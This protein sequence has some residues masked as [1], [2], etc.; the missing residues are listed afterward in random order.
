MRLTITLCALLP[1][2][3]VSAA[4][5]RRAPSPPV[6]LIQSQMTKA[7]FDAAG[8]SKLSAGELLALNQWLNAFAIA[9][10]SPQGPS[11]GESVIE[12][13]IEGDFE[14]WS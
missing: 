9:L 1:A 8:L 5:K 13:E 3:S 10:I 7:Q 2:T 6:L 12:T 4:P 14:G 11:A